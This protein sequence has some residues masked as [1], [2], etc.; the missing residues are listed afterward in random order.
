M[1]HGERAHEQLAR[2]RASVAAGFD[3][4]VEMPLE[5]TDLP[6]V[7]RRYQEAWASKNVE[8]I[9]A[10]HDA[11]M[12]FHLHAW[13]GYAVAGED[14]RNQFEGFFLAWPDLAFDVHREVLAQKSYICEYTMSA[15]VPSAPSRRFGIDAVDVIRWQDELIV[16]KDTYLDSGAALG[17]LA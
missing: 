3:R 12:V 6:L 2:R 7:L 17:Q 5:R 14:V 10:L 9:L 1:F 13:G 16:R 11:G 4:D 15:S 8:A